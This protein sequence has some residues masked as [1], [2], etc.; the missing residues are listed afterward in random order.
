VFLDLK[1]AIRSIAVAPRFAA[2]VIVTLALGTGA[3]TAVFSV[4]NAVV[5]K[6]L[7]YDEPERLV[8]VYHS[9]GDD[10][11]YLTGLA[12]VDYRD[13]S[14]TLDIAVT[15][16]YSV[17]GADL[18]SR[19]EPERVRTMLVSA[20]YFRVLR[21]QPILGQTFDRAD[22]RPNSHIAVISG[23]IW[24]KYLDARADAAGRL[25]TLDGVAYR[26]VGV[27]PDDFDDPLESDVDV[28][29]PLNLQAG[30]PNS[31]DNYYLSIVAR[32]KPAVSVEQ[33][34]A[35]LGALA[36][37]MQRDRPPSAARWSARVV[38]LQIDTVGSARSMLW[39]LLGAVG[40]LMVIACV[41]VASLLLARGA[42]R[43]TD[44]AVRAALGCSRIRL[45]RQLLL[46]S[47]LL[48]L[49]GA[50]A[51]L[52]MAPAV[53]RVLLA[54]APAAVAQA[55]T[56]TPERAVLAFTV[57]VALL[58]GVGF[59]VAPAAQVARTDLEGV[60]RESGRTGS[61]SRR[62]TRAR[63]VLVVW[64]VALALVLLVG[65]GLLLRSFERLRSV[66]LG[67]RPSH[68]MTFAVNLPTGRYADP[69]R[70]ARFYREFEARLAAL[71]G[72]RSAA[73][74]SRLPVTGSFHSWG[75]Q[76]VDTPTDS[77]FTPAQQRVIEGPYFEA[78]GIPLL[79]GRTFTT[80][81]DVRAPRRV[82]ISQELARQV[83]PSE[84]PLGQRLRVAGA[85]VE[86]IG[87]VGNVALSARASPLPYVYH[88][89]SQFAAD[90]NWELVQVVALDGD[91]PSLLTDARRELSQIDPA[92]VLYEPRMLGEVIGGGVAQERFALLLVAGFALLALMLA[93]LGIYGVLTYSVNR[94]TR[95]M[96]IR[97][98]LGAPTRAVR[99]M[100]VRDGARLAAIGIGVG[101]VTA[102]AA[103]RSLQSLLFGV[104][105]TE[106]LVF[107]GAAGVL[108]CVAIVASWI[109]AR[110][111]TKAD[112]L[113]A[114]R[115]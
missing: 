30:G 82:V 24:R 70:R 108:G 53:T 31:F 90:R 20:D 45:V 27:V 64:Q 71:P 58:A 40:L 93:A 79:R 73:A 47:L 67:V 3:N 38:P 35:E 36:A 34:Q 22:E 1:Y 32:L 96:G 28:W 26:V 18:T 23:R 17:K 49:A 114:V 106:P 43:E 101:F 86:I 68:V 110:R 83:F 88:L 92:L 104:S 50:V 61:G 52:L 51:G 5:L 48:S 78:V 21:T 55:G 65:A 29:T 8:R 102:L 7:P 76:R 113:Q 91:R 6:P 107:A 54:L 109:P 46:E 42:A 112:P 44:L 63:N 39:I 41:N 81:D 80:E 111:A 75:V 59:G 72:V 100:I 12:A 89:H 57:A 4:L 98:A 62:Q 19:G 66:A 77:R 69:E 14:R 9:S 25:L 13:H 87:V 60:L 95:E 103:T 85:E 15:Y 33:A 97:M 10:Y 105:A 94:R 115:D 2:V 84:N 11:S 37:N 99:S 16:T 56:G 74:I